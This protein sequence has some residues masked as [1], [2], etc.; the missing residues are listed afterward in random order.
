MYL[1]NSAMSGLE[2]NGRELLPKLENIS[3]LRAL[4]GE[5]F[6]KDHY[7]DKY[8]NIEKILRLCRKYT[9]EIA[10]YFSDIDNK[11]INMED[12]GSERFIKYQ[13]AFAYI[14]DYL[15]ILDEIEIL[16]LSKAQ[17]LRLFGVE[18]L[19]IPSNYFS[20]LI[21]KK[22]GVDVESVMHRYG[23]EPVSLEE[24]KEQEDEEVF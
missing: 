22:K 6:L 3:L 10:S 16:L 9:S 23:T 19:S 21:S 18:D 17:E 20:Y 11:I 15:F 1:I 12:L 5:D 2:T 13:Y 14:F 8:D 24:I 7:K 4:V